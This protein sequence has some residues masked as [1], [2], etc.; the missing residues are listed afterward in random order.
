MRLG[1]EGA[2]P[3]VHLGTLA[4]RFTALRQHSFAQLG[5]AAH[6]LECFGGVADHEVQFDGRKTA[7][8][9]YAGG[10]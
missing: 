3:G 2:H 7:P 9:H 10:L 8:I 5:D 4:H 6:I 1:N